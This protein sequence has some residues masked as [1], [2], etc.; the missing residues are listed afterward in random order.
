MLAL[1]PAVNNTEKGKP[2]VRTPK[3]LV[4]TE[5]LY[6]VSALISELAKQERYSEALLPVC[7][8]DDWENAARDEGWEPKDGL[9][10]L[11]VDTTLSGC[12]PPDWQ[13]LCAE[14]DIDPQQNEAFEHWIVT[15]WLADKL[16]GQGEMVLRDFFGLTIWGRACTGQAIYLDSVM[17][18]IHRDLVEHEAG[19]A[20]GAAY[21]EH[22]LK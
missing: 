17:Q 22:R 13:G 18:R 4:E 6:C 1:K 21:I 19:F 10:V 7:V 3:Q 20:A 8:Q 5:V 16:E 12:E 2:M 9:F 11:G 14:H 15:P